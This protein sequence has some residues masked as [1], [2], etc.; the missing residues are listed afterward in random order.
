MGAGMPIRLTGGIRSQK[1]I[2]IHPA[3]YNPLVPKRLIIKRS[4][5][6]SEGSLKS[7]ARK[8]FHHARAAGSG[9]H[10]LRLAGKIE[11]PGIFQSRG[12][13]EEMPSRFAKV[14]PRIP[15]R[16]KNPPRRTTWEKYHFPLK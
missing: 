5:N 15:E 7:L 12:T 1:G 3:F 16:K 9:N 13:P 11:V 10:R 14:T 8:E 4:I 6:N 2:S